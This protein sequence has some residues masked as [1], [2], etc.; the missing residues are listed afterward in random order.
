MTQEN[1]EPD[2]PAGYGLHVLE[3]V[4]STLDE[5]RRIAPGLGGPVWIMAHRQTAGRGRRGRPWTDP[6]GN[7]ISTLVL[8]HDDPPETVALRSFVAALALFDAV[9]GV[10]GNTEGLALKWPNDV[11]LN[12]GKL[13][14][15]LLESA[16]G[17]R[18]HL[19]IGIGVNLA[20]T[21]D[22]GNLEPT[23]LRP[24]S[25][26]EERGVSVLPNDFLQHLAAAYARYETQ[27]TTFGF[28][29]IRAAW[30]ERAAR[31]GEPLTARLPNREITGRFDTVD[32]HGNL[33]LVTP[34][35]R[36]KIAAG[37]IFF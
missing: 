12:G 33:V 28:A 27:F 8:P 21:P 16:S 25:L 17:T 34:E 13:A 3:E 22:T 10:T 1:R 23:A 35:G 20:R 30:L 37:D 4:D 7:L 14:G 32:E 9:A 18:G 29:P 11:L 5:A 19:A 6:A 24:V 15:I 2:W 31:L 26:A 36:E